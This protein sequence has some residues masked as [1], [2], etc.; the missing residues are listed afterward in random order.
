[1]IGCIVTCACPCLGVSFSN[2][3]CYCLG[4]CTLTSHCFD[5]VYASCGGLQIMVI[6]TWNQPLGHWS[7]DL[8]MLIDLGYA[9]I[10]LVGTACVEDVS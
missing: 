7:Y 10:T 4:I 9:R 2:N 6:D 3:G 8:K 1:M 5:K